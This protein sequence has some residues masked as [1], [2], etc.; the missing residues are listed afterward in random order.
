MSRAGVS[1]AS[2]GNRTDHG[3]A[4]S[5]WEASRNNVASS[6]NRP[7]KWTPIG[8]P[9]AFQKSGTDIAGLPVAFATHR[10][11]ATNDAL[12]AASASGSGGCPNGGPE[13]DEKRVTLSAELGSAVRCEGRAQKT[14]VCG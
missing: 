10:G 6:P 1:P 5:S 14:V 2:T 7:R 3:R 13:R 11:K 8:K 9:S 12:P 4:A